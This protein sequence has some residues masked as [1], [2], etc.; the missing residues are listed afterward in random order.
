MRPEYDFRGAVRGRHHRRLDKGYT[1][2]VHQPDGTTVI[3]HYQL[4][5]G[6]ILL[7]PDVRA[8]FPDS[9]AVNKALRSLI[10]LMA[11]MPPES[12]KPQPGTHP[13]ASD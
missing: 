10:T 9:E 7:Q 8:Y 4:V 2:E 6:A 5:E 1:V 12:K 13:V 11:E 3:E